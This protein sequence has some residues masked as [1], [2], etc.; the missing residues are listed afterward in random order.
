[1]VINW[2][3]IGISQ[4]WKEKVDECQQHRM[5]IIAHQLRTL[6]HLHLQAIHQLK[7][8]AAVSHVII[9]NLIMGG[10]RGFIYGHVIST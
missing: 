9:H 6:E 10:A 1:M 5:A 2:D 4:L 7:G 3:H 8:M